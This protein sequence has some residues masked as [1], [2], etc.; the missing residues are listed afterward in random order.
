MTTFNPNKLYKNPKNAR[1]MGVCA[2]IGDYFD[3]RPGILRMLTIIG[4]LLGMFTPI[5]FGYFILGFMLDKKPSEISEK[6]EEE[7]FW[8]KARTKPDYTRVDLTKRFDD[9]E[10]RTREMEA[11]MTSKVFKLSRE[12]RELEEKE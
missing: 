6:P 4:C 3:V 12:L 11:Y 9:I 1:C 5:I 8:K 10:K 7:A 2:G